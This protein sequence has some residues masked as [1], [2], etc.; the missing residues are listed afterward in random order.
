MTFNLNDTHPVFQ[1]VFDRTFGLHMDALRIMPYDTDAYILSVRIIAL[2][3]LPE[4]HIT[5]E[6]CA[7]GIGQDDYDLDVEGNYSIR[8]I[9]PIRSLLSKEL[10]QGIHEMHGSLAIPQDGR[11]VDAQFRYALYHFDEIERIIRHPNSI[12]LHPYRQDFTQLTL[13]EKLELRLQSHEMGY[14]DELVDEHGEKLPPRYNAVP[15]G[16]SIH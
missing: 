16:V 4:L 8:L 12:E 7:A 6:Q 9:H 14:E 15:G 11:R 10:Y 3:G 2:D 13:E 1:A 5:L